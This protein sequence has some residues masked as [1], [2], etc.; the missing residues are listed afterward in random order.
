MPPRDRRWP[1]LLFGLLLFGS[2]LPSA[3]GAP[4]SPAQDESRQQLEQLYPSL[5]EPAW[6]A[7]FV[8]HVRAGYYHEVLAREPETG[9]Y[10]WTGE[11][12]MRFDGEPELR[13]HRWTRVYGKA[14][15]YPLLR[16]EEVDQLWG[17]TIHIE[18]EEDPP[19]L[20]RHEGGTTTTS[21]VTTAEVL[22]PEGRVPDAE[23]ASAETGYSFTAPWLSFYSGLDQRAEHTLIARRV[24]KD[25]PADLIFRLDGPFYTSGFAHRLEHRMFMDQS[26]RVISIHRGTFEE[27]Y[28]RT[29]EAAMADITGVPSAEYAAGFASARVEEPGSY[30]TNIAIALSVALVL[31]FV[32]IVQGRGADLP[33]WA[34]LV[35]G[36][37]V[38]GW[39]GAL[40]LTDTLGLGNWLTI[41]GLIAGT[42]VAVDGAFHWK[43]KRLEDRELSEVLARE[44]EIL[45]ELRQARSRGEEP[46]RVLQGR[47]KTLRLRQYLLGKLDG[48]IESSA[49]RYMKRRRVGTAPGHSSA[50]SR[51]ARGTAGD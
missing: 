25:A 2:A 48:R 6:F 41:F 8:N 23:L 35:T 28:R 22:I 37:I 19:R 26:G 38:V 39:F 16:G 24:K 15:P 32:V 20:L 13:R 45:N 27:L 47:F 1:S 18:L 42:G 34:E 50:S 51:A 5:F 4:V 44:E 30:T 7:V 49:E 36:L 14:P 3:R 10:V 12:A 11:T 21:P 40:L 33:P 31:G 17:E 46:V 29:R 43:T 9:R